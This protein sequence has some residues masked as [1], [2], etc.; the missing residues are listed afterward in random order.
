MT[1]KLLSLAVI[2]VATLTVAA[3]PV[4][5]S[6]ESFPGECDLSSSYFNR[7]QCY[8][9]TVQDAPPDS[10]A[11]WPMCNPGFDVYDPGKC[12]AEKIEHGEA[13]N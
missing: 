4:V 2:P 8:I 7:S 11:H 6:G 1:K 13:P 10:V 9:D 12:A 5:R 3:A